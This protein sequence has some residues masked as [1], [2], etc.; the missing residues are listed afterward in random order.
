[1]NIKFGSDFTLKEMFD[2]G[3]TR[4]YYVLIPLR[5]PAHRSRYTRILQGSNV[6]M[7][8]VVV[9]NRYRMHDVQDGPS[10]DGFG[11][12]EKELGVKGDA[13]QDNMDLD[14][15]LTQEQFHSTVVG[16]ISNDFDVNEFE[17]EEEE[18]DMI[19]DVVS[20]DSDDS[21]DD[22]GGTDAMATTADVMPVLVHTMPLPV[23]TEVLQGVHAQ[24]RL[25]TNLAA[26]DIP[27]DLW[28]RISEAQ[29]YVPPPPYIATELERLRS[30]NVPF[31]GVPN[32]R[33]VSMT[34][35][36]VYDTGLQICRNSL[37]NHE[38]ETLR[39]GMIFN[40]MSEMKLFL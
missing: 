35:M 32:Y 20:S 33:D 22:Q 8:E 36:T 17:Q 9:E 10:S 14:G 34:D 21:D 25:V 38:T 39:K 5:D 6:A 37:Y 28:A 2:T 7:A 3:K 29:Q 4:A 15:Q 19:D 1:L 27:Y 12:N 11:G 13:S 40:T 16:C 31:R 23:P 26:D 18:E 30:K 24:G